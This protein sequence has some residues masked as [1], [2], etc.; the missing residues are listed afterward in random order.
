MKSCCVRYS[1][2][3]SAISLPVITILINLQAFFI[4]SRDHTSEGET[5]S[6]FILNPNF[7]VFMLTAVPLSLALRNRPEQY[8]VLI[9]SA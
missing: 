8:N 4:K 7:P 1:T 5:L 9:E 3:F 6:V 2:C